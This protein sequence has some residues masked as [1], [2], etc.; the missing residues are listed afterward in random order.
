MPLDLAISEFND[1]LFTANNDLGLVFGPSLI[2]QRIR[3]RLKII[4][5]SW[6]YDT[7]KTL[8]S[9]L[10]QILHETQQSAASKVEPLVRQALLPMKDIRVEGV[11]VFQGVTEREIMIRV[12]YSQTPSPGVT[13]GFQPTVQQVEFPLSFQP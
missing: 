10:R 9:D 6:I 7:N 5:G 1:L 8:G 12:N 11:D 13:P 2:E 3:L 4:R